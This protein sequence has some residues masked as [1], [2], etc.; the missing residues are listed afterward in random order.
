MNVCSASACTIP[1]LPFPLS[2]KEQGRG[3][4]SHFL[5]VCRLLRPA[6]SQGGL[7]S[8][9]ACACLSQ[10]SAPNS[11]TPVSIMGTSLSSTCT[12]RM[13]LSI[14]ERLAGSRLQGT[15]R[16]ITCRGQQEEAAL[17]K[18]ASN[19]IDQAFIT[20]QVGHGGSYRTK[21]RTQ[22]KQDNIYSIRGQSLCELIN[23]SSIR[24]DHICSSITFTSLCI[25]SKGKDLHVLPCPLRG[26]SP[27]S[28]SVLPS[29]SSSRQAT[30]APSASISWWS[31]SPDWRPR[32]ER[33]YGSARIRLTSRQDWGS[34]LKEMTDMQIHF[35]RGVHTSADGSSI[36]SD[37]F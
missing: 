3:E 6:E 8:C 36:S 24:T 29:V 10:T 11:M 26:S 19:Q 30:A 12:S 32:S 4:S 20:E 33:R 31:P 17:W 15:H 35:R 16:W 28:R 13:V 27:S 18:E 22:V 37:V 9:D 34:S 14:W 21:N 23:N 7:A 2:D 5:F 25:V 1:W